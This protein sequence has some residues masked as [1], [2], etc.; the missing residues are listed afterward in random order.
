MSTSVNSNYAAVAEPFLSSELPEWMLSARIV[1]FD[2]LI[3][4]DL[5]GKRDNVLIKVLTISIEGHF[6]A[7]AMSYSVL[8]LPEEK[9][10]FGP[11]I[12]SEDSPRDLSQF[13]FTGLIEGFRVSMDL[14]NVPLAKRAQLEHDLLRNGFQLNPRH[15]RF[16]G[17]N[18][19]DCGAAEVLQP[20]DETN[21]RLFQTVAFPLQEEVSFLY[22]IIDNATGREFQS[23]AIHNVAG[24][25]RADGDRPFRFFTEP[26]IF[27]PRSVI[28][29]QITEISGNSR[30][31]FVLQG[32]KVLGANRTV[33]NK[34]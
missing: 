19:S 24:L 26:I 22:S 29:V 18:L 14:R 25:G 17:L 9:I 2:Q 20:D 27:A 10:E 15:P 12:E 30:L 32:Y 21:S 1:P 11:N 16:A 7:T 4:F 33:D 28:R 31:Y 6:V 13:T 34:L 8:P 3:T 5:T 23:E